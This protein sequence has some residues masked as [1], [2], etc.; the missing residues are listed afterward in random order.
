[1]GLGCRN[2]RLRRSE[3][4]RYQL[5]AFSLCTGPDRLNASADA[6]AERRRVRGRGSVRG[7][8][9]ERR[10]GERERDSMRAGYETEG[11]GEGEI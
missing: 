1:M 8:E 7:V 5:P 11:E 9:E 3:P 10:G 4:E 2:L 6:P